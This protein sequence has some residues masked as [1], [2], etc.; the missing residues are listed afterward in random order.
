MMSPDSPTPAEPSGGYGGSNIAT[1]LLQVGGMIY[2]NAQQR[3]MQQKTID[4]N[5]EQAKYAYSQELEMMN[6]MNDY[7]SPAAQMQRYKNAGLNPNM[8][9]G[10]GG[11]SSGN[12]A[13]IPKYNAPTLQYNMNPIVQIPEM[14]SMY[15]DFSMKQAQINNLKAQN[16]SIRQN[17]MTSA[18]QAGLTSVKTKQGEEALR[19]SIY[20]NPYQASIIANQARGSEAELRQKWQQLKLMSQQEQ[21]AYL[22]Q[23]YLEKQITG[24]GIENERKQTEVLYN[25]YRNQWM[26]MGITTSDNPLLRI[27]TRMMNETGIDLG[28]ITDGWND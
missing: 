13:S 4:A 6:R 14:I 24:A 9:Y 22:N 23:Q 5:K 15:Q 26:K 16:D 17:T 21:T 2:N 1:A 20:T 8:I 7:N 10:S 11:G 19:Q 18:M 12:Q 28:F 25:Q 27:F 3:R